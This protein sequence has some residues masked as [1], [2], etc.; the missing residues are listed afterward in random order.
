MKRI[1]V[2]LLAATIAATGGLASAASADVSPQTQAATEKAEDLTA[3][4]LDLL[5][6]DT[7]TAK[8][9]A[10]L[11]PAFILLRADGTHAD[12]AAY[13]ENPSIVE[14]YDITDVEARRTGR[15]IVARY[16]LVVDSTIDGQRQSGDPA[17]RLSVFVKGDAGWQLAAHSNFNSLVTD[18]EI[19]PTT[20]QST[21]S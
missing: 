14:S 6:E 19:A 4:F 20:T 7:P 2:I 10:F 16:T 13:L 5:A 21:T 3:K 17:P 15:V 8:L 1:V 9:D 11:S 12:K 18:P